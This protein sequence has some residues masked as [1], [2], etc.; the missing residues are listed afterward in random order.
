MAFPL[1]IGELTKTTDSLKEALDNVSQLRKATSTAVQTLQ[2]TLAVIQRIMDLSF[3]MDTQTKAGVKSV[4]NVIAAVLPTA[5]EAFDCIKGTEDC[6]GILNIY[7][8]LVDVTLRQMQTL[9]KEP[10]IMT[11]VNSLMDR[12]RTVTT[13]T[14]SR[15]T[16]TAGRN[17]GAIL[18]TGDDAK[19]AT[20]GMEFNR[21]IGI[22]AG[23]HGVYD[24]I[25][26]MMDLAYVAANA[27][28]G[29]EGF[30]TTV[31]GD[32]CISVSQ[33]LQGV[34]AEHITVIQDQFR[35]VPMIG[36]LIAGPLAA[37]MK[38]VL[39]Q[40]QT[41]GVHKNGEVISTLTGLVAVMELLSPSVVGSSFQRSLMFILRQIRPPAKC[42]GGKTSCVGLIR[43]LEMI[44]DGMLMQVQRVPL[45]GSATATSMRWS[46][47]TL[48]KAIRDQIGATVKTAVSALEVMR[49]TL[50][51]I[52]LSQLVP[53][54]DVILA[55]AQKAVECALSGGM[56]LASLAGHV[57][58]QFLMQLLTHTPQHIPGLHLHSPFVCCCQFAITSPH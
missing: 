37:L 19:L 34:L 41:D 49:V 24:S 12:F 57:D 40:L 16:A 33:R 3:H 4:I 31:F 22:A 52:G 39:V 7:R 44:S 35:H 28:L 53:A 13:M 27:T 18:V 43:I 5:Q 48:F 1:I 56:N 58:H 54:L 29:C 10:A 45:V 25:A 11:A 42:G 30:N 21:V 20:I 23:N 15:S 9:A 51:S 6:S 17:V 36:G 32:P 50:Y 55:G 47:D 14:T 2:G 8:G 46:L 38:G 26:S